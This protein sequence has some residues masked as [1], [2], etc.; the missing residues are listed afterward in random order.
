MV[1]CSFT[2]LKGDVVPRDEEIALKYAKMAA[3]SGSDCSMFNY[4]IILSEIDKEMNQA[5]IM[6]YLKQA[7]DLGNYRAMAAYAENLYKMDK[8]KNFKE[9]FKLSKG[10]M[11][12]IYMDIYCLLIKNT[13]KYE[14]RNKIYKRI[15]K[16]G[17]CSCFEVLW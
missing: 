10:L 6:K 13:S 5:E 3:D 11:G 16:Y 4:T 17:I 9:A 12:F 8:E 7:M 15:C 1:N 2:Y 14:E